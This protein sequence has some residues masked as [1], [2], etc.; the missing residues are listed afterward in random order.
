MI[1]RFRKVDRLSVGT[2]KSEAQV[3]LANDPRLITLSLQK[4]RDRWSVFFNQRRT[5]PILDSAFQATSP[6]VPTGQQTV[7]SGRETADG[8]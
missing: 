2:L 5:V 3:P 1:Q 7:P 4:R 6:A 8:V